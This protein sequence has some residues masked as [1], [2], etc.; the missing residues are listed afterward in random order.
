MKVIINYVTFRD[1]LDVYIDYEYVPTST[2]YT[3]VCNKLNEY[4]GET[5]FKTKE[6]AQDFYKALG[7]RLMD[8]SVFYCYDSSENVEACVM[9]KLSRVCNKSDILLD[10]YLP[11]YN[12]LQEDIKSL[13]SKQETRF[14][15]TPTSQGNYVANNYTSTITQVTNS[16]DYDIN[17]QVNYLKEKLQGLIDRYC[18]Q[19][20]EFKIWTN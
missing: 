2:W 1:V 18:S 11:L 7:I 17:T 12:K 4:Y 20:E 16:V 10:Q 9:H 5:C 14:N 6:G 15:D 3:K 13:D 19:F 8:K